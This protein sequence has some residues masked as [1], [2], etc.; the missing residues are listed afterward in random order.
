ME[1][2]CARLTK[3][4]Y[5]KGKS[6]NRSRVSNIKEAIH[7]AWERLSFDFA[8]NLIESML[9]RIFN[10]ICFPNKPCGYW[11]TKLL[12]INAKICLQVTLNN[13][14]PQFINGLKCINYSYHD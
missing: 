2:V 7:S 6:Y 13:L 4:F 1:N 9:N 14:S 8:A 5:G 12:K 11:I 10:V 3:V